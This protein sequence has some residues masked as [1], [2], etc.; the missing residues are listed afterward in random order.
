MCLTDI[1]TDVKEMDEEGRAFNIG[2]TFYVSSYIRNDN[3]DTQ[4][5]D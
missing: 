3:E 2:V 1:R 5:R 4:R